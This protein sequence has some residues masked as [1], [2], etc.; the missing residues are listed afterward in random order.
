[1]RPVIA[2]TWT[3][4]A[5]VGDPKTNEWRTLDPHWGLGAYDADSFPESLRIMEIDGIPIAYG[6]E[7]DRHLDGGTLHYTGGSFLV[8]KS[9][10]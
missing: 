10:I 2:L 6:F 3:V 4:G 8:E 9:A 7:S 1:M 5:K